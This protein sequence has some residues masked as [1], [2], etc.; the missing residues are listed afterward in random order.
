N[1]GFRVRAPSG[2][3][4]FFFRSLAVNERRFRVPGPSGELAFLFRSPA[5]NER[6][7]ARRIPLRPPVRGPPPVAPGPALRPGAPRWPPSR[8]AGGGRRPP[9]S[10]PAGRRGTGRPGRARPG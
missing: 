10:W 4:A 3:L 6:R 1:A 9:A 7:L 2:E 8:G 5:V